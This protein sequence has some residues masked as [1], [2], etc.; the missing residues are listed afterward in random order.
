MQYFNEAGRLPS[1][2]TKLICLNN[3][4]SLLLWK[5]VSCELLFCEF[6][7]Q[8]F[9]HQISFYFSCGSRYLDKLYQNLSKCLRNRT[10]KEVFRECF[11]VPV[12]FA[13]GVKRNL[14]Q[15]L[16]CSFCLPEQ[17]FPSLVHSC[18]RLKGCDV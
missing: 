2:S 10:Y 3:R 11:F 16:N 1:I 17:K 14:M 15:S 7:L 9:T 6:L 5:T 8:K 4:F 12:R 13:D 18:P